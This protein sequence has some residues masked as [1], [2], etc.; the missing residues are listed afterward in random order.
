MCLWLYPSVCLSVK[1]CGLPL[2]WQNFCQR[3]RCQ[4]FKCLAE[5]LW[6]WAGGG[7]G[8]QMLVQ[9]SL[10]ITEA[11][12]VCLLTFCLFFFFCFSFSFFFF[13]FFFSPS[14]SFFPLFSWKVGRGGKIFSSTDL[15]YIILTWLSQGTLCNTYKQTLVSYLSCRMQRW[16]DA[17][18][19]LSGAEVLKT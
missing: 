4:H 18:L 9:K 12:E 6:L 2:E 10:P 11:D 14:F 17:L 13:S 8:G 15:K 1:S 19:L 3:F 16:R 5:L 7:R